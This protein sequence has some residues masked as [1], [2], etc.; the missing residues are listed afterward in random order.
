ML[1]KGKKRKKHLGILDVSK[2]N[3]FFRKIHHKLLTLMCV[4]VWG[5]ISLQN[6]SELSKILL[7]KF[8][9]SV[10]FLTLPNL[11][12][13]ISKLKRGFRIS[14]QSVIE[15]NCN[16]SRTSNDIDMK[17]V[18][19]TKLG[20][21]NKTALEKFDVDVL[22]VN[23]DVIVI[24]KIYGQFGSRIPDAQ[25]VKPTFSLTVTL[26]LTKTENRTKNFFTKFSDI[27]LS[28]VTIFTKNY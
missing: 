24:F 25:P 4:C 11:Q 2:K 21:I 19:E 18:P 1:R 6:F 9:P 13:Q 20:M 12:M 28:K 7:D 14:S 16:N 10:V 5:G 8:V 3:K 26:Y 22:L 15:E 23:C 17:L 27:G